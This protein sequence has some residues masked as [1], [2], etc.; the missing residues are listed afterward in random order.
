MKEDA[1]YQ[2]Y[3]LTYSYISYSFWKADD[4][5]S[6]FFGFNIFRKAA[7]DHRVR[8]LFLYVDFLD[9]TLPLLLLYWTLGLAAKF[10]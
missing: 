10:E 8:R 5:S 1:I 4:Y 6:L 3:F 9:F 7:V 2:K